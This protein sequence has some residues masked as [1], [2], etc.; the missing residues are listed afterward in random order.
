[1]IHGKQ[2]KTSTTKPQHIAKPFY[3][4]KIPHSPKML[5]TTVTNSDSKQDYPYAMSNGTKSLPI[6]LRKLKPVEDTE[7]ADSSLAGCALWYSGCHSCNN[8]K[9]HV[10]CTMVVMKVYHRQK[11]MKENVL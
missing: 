1:M 7:L 11:N 3:C 6:S 8:M 10:F 5:I 9:E 2:N 4:F